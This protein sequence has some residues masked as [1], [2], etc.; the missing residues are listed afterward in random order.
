M[1]DPNARL[2]TWQWKA[3]IQRTFARLPVLQ[4][5]A[6]Y[7][8]QRMFGHYRATL[9]PFFMLSGCAELVANL[10]A[11]G[12]SVNGARVMEVGTGRGIDLPIGFFLC[13]AVSVVTFDL[14][15]YLKPGIVMTSVRALCGDTDR[16]V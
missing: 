2:M 15:R 4:E 1:I 13:G 6:Y 12:K 5:P 9:D 16:V 10:Q 8:A 14:H 3:R 7:I 11:A